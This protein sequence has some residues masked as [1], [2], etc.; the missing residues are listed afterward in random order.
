[1]D[2]LPSHTL[3][4]PA[5]VV[6]RWIFHFRVAFGSNEIFRFQ[7][8]Y[9][10]TIGVWGVLAVAFVKLEFDWRFE[11]WMVDLT[12][13]CCIVAALDQLDDSKT[14]DC[15]VVKK[16]AIMGHSTRWGEIVRGSDIVL[17]KAAKIV[18]YR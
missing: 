2:R 15:G 4:V 1:M 14:G 16:V 3:V 10:C 13:R 9:P 7:L 6:I 17:P 18:K 5:L 11:G 8:V 12:E